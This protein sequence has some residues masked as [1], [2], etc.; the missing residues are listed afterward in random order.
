[1]ISDFLF[2]VLQISWRGIV[3]IAYCLRLSQERTDCTSN[4]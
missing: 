4:I 1:L 3:E 2:F